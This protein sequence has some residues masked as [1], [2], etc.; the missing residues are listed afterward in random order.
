LDPEP[1]PS[2]PSSF[3]SPGVEEVDN[4]PALDFDRSGE[5]DAAR[6]PLPVPDP[7]PVPVPGPDSNPFSM[8]VAAPDRDG[9]AA[10]QD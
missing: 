2:L 5:V 6:L 4:R 10:S 3:F 7:D 9:P 8:F 1:D